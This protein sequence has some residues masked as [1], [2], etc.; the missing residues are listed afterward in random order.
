LTPSQIAGIYNAD[1]LYAA[2]NTGQGII[3]GLF[4]LSGYTQSDIRTYEKQFGLPNVPVVN[5]P[6]PTLGGPTDSAGAAEV[7]LD[8]E[9][10]IALAPGAS[11]IL[12]YNAPPS[13]LGIILQYLQ[14]AFDDA[15]ASISTSWG[16]CELGTFPALLDG[17]LIASIKM[18]LQGQSI[19]AASGD[20]GAFD[21][22]PLAG[23][24]ALQ[25][26]DPAS[27]PYFV[28]TGGTSLGAFDP[29]SNPNPSYPAGSEVIWNNGCT[30]QACSG[31]GGGGVSHNWPDPGYQDASPGVIE[32]G[33]SQNGAWCNQPPG[34]LCREVPDVSL[35]ADPRTGYSIYCTDPVGCAGKGWPQIGGTSAAAP[36]WAAIGAL[37]DTQFGARVGPFFFLYALDPSGYGAQLHDIT[38]GDNGFYPAGPTYDMASGL[39]TPDITLLVQQP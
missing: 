37:V 36:L 16:I 22:G 35:N 17:E 4:E 23:G 19:F 3:L 10:Q 2:G 14:I 28:G 33:L 11:G 6:N 9:L 21:C 15:A 24:N 8:I 39:G 1:P 13:F 29:G 27:Q 32:P 5:L 31:A 34:T 30:P 7:E 38:G 18:L 20:S 25:V 26:D 12:V